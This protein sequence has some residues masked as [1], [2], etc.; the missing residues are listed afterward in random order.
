MTSDEF[1][2]WERAQRERHHYVR[3]EIST[4]RAVQLGTAFSAHR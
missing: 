2:V 3:G 1:L 4:R